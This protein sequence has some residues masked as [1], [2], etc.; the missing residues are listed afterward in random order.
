VLPTEADEK[1][2]EEI[3]KSKDWVSQMQLN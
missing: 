3:I 2:L 1:L